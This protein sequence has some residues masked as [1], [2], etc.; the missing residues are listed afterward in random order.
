MLQKRFNTTDCVRSY[1]AMMKKG[2][3]KN[4]I[5]GFDGLRAIAVLLV[6]LQHKAGIGPG[7][8]GVW[9][10]FALSGFLITGILREQRARIEA[11]KSGYAHELKTFLLR[12]SLRIFPAYYFVLG[13]LSLFVAAGILAPE[14]QAGLPYHFAY[15]SNIWIGFI[16]ENWPG[17]FSHFWSLAVEEQ[18]YLAFAPLLLAFP[19]RRHWHLCL[20][21]VLVGVACLW[22]LKAAGASDILVYT[23]PL[24]NFWLL[25][26]GGMG[27]LA[28]AGAGTKWRG[29]MLHPYAALLLLACIF[30]LPFAA[31]RWQEPPVSAYVVIHFLIG[32]STAGLV[33]WVAWNQQ[34]ALTRLLELHWLAALGRISYGFYLFHALVPSPSQSDRVAAVFGADGVPAWLRYIDLPFTFAVT[35]VL[36]M[37][38]WKCIEKPLLRLRDASP[39]AAR[40]EVRI[41]AIHSAD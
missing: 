13:V 39:K 32:L 27:C 23:H 6:F 28:L 8:L 35:V 33:S 4:R 31:S 29:V 16:H 37:L 9:I 36:A 11:G 14:Y 1:T 3:M 2:K 21:I 12:R 22:T 30:F 5:R 40:A 19:A 26:L 17:P 20:A 18:F 10:F 24:A 25:A 41:D 15:L 34:S 7:Y 38:S